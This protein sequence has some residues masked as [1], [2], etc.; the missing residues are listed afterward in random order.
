MGRP[1][2]FDRDDA[3]RA[4]VQ[5]FWRQGYAAT[6]ASDLVAAMGIGRQSFYDTFGDK[7]QCYLETLRVYA[8]EEVGAQLDGTSRHATSPLEQLRAFLR[9]VADRPDPRRLLGCMIVNALAEGGDD[10]E[11]AAAL[12]PSGQRLR[13]AVT[14]LLR[15]AKARGEVAASLD[16]GRAA[17]ALL[18]TRMGLMLS[19]KGGQPPA[20]LR[21]LADA[22]G[23]TAP[24]EEKD[25]G[26]TVVRFGV[27]TKMSVPKR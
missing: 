3:L 20:T 10:A 22:K 4:A 26:L 17:H 24:K 19:A 15:A 1:K 9:V 12:G 18:L 11:V 21:S 8:R 16:E 6:T 14:E 23:S 25:A 2:E 13:Q 5:V 27:P 7:R